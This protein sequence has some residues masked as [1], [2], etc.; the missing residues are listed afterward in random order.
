MMKGGQ[1]E[2]EAR[3][4]IRREKLVKKGGQGEE[5]VV[6]GR[7]KG[8]WCV[9]RGRTLKKK[10]EERGKGMGITRPLQDAGAWEA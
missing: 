4:G 3:G 5:K 2:K 7:A 1:G 9:G 6:R 8:Q 10:G